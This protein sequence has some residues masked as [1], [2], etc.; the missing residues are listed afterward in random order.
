MP[1]LFIV[2]FDL[3]FCGWSYVCF[4]QWVDALPL[5]WASLLS[6]YC[7]HDL[8]S[9]GSSFLDCWHPPLIWTTFSFPAMD[10]QAVGNIQDLVKLLRGGVNQ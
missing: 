8:S 1:K 7:G 10:V 3:S 6:C 9:N 2:L 5:M 4:L